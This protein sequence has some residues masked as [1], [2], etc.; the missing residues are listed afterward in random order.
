MGAGRFGLR[1]I[2][3]LLIGGLGQHNVALAASPAGASAGADRGTPRWQA[4]AQPSQPQP[5][6]LVTP[7]LY[8][9]LLRRSWEVYG[10]RFIQ[11][12]GR[13][14]DF[15]AADDRTT[16]EGQAYAMVRA[17]L[18]NDRVRFDQTLAWAEQHLNR[19]GDALWAWHWVKQGGIQDANFATDADIDAVTAL[20]L[21]ARRWN[22]PAYE[23]LAQQ[24]LKDIRRLAIAEIRSP[25]DRPSR[26]F[27]L[28]G[29]RDAFQ[30]LPELT[31]LNPSYFAPA[32]YRL[33]AQ[34][35]AD[36]DWLGL[37]DDGYVLLDRMTAVSPVGLPAD[38]LGVNPQ[39]GEFGPVPPKRSLQSHYSFDAY[40]VW[41]RVSLDHTWF[42]ESRA[43]A[44]LQR[45]LRPLAQRWQAEQSIPAV[46][47]LEGAAEVDYDATAQYAMLY[48]AMKQV[49][50]S[51]ASALFIRKLLGNYSRGLWDNNE[52]YYTQNLAWFALLPAAG[53]QPLLHPVAPR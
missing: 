39:T 20:I 42:G 5:L 9:A 41:W 21:A 7:S 46:L 4:C 10:D 31:I 17:V 3:V 12:D 22:C 16:S 50:P 52:A 18:I 47:N 11:A 1:A 27:I 33:F 49:D 51:V 25:R 13:V 6:A 23:T 26:R 15:Q 32:A 28:P 8:E 40:R 35:D 24:K 37:I 38:W 19:P 48:P 34:V 2:L 53:P 14:V 29:P 43:A 44:Y 36:Y 30:P 45:N